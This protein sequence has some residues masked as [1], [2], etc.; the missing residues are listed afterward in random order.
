L[1]AVYRAADLFVHPSVQ[2]T[3]GLVALEAQACGTPVVGIRG[4]YMDRIILSDQTHWAEENSPESLATAILES[5][6]LDLTPIAEAASR[7]VAKRYS[8]RRVFRQMF[9]FYGQLRS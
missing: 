7:Q 5:R 1:A 2:E 4:S 9:D 8:W 6:K 3:F